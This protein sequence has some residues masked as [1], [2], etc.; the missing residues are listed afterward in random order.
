[1]GLPYVEATLASLPGV[2]RAVVVPHLE[3]ETGQAL[4]LIAHLLPDPSAAG[5]AA[6]DERSWLA[7]LRAA[8]RKE[9]P[10]HALPAHWML[11]SGLAVG[12]GE[13]RKLDRR[14][15]PLPDA[16]TKRGSSKGADGRASPAASAA[17]APRHAPSHASIG[18]TASELL[19]AEMIPV[20]AEVLGV[21]HVEPDDSFFDLGAQRPPRP[22]ASRL[23]PPP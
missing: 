13:A 12:A 3:P 9:L 14:S 16:L 15:L 21:E 18:R 5:R 22:M 1:M 2:A 20:W 4:A 6:A 19:Q 8:A 17:S 11:I 7:S 23:P 10:H